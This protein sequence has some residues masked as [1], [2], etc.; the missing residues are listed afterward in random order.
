M[1]DRTDAPK[2]V[3]LGKVLDPK[4]YDFELKSPERPE[5][6]QSRLRLAELEAE[7]KLRTQEAE[8]RHRRL[9]VLIVHVFVIAVVAVAFAICGYIV[10]V[11]GPDSGLTDKAMVLIS[12]IV[13][14]GVGYMT[15]KGGK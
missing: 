4:K 15:G 5:E 12:V 10:L 6:L 7:H 8:D 11:K 14:A 9:I 1:A 2:N 13:S 3:D